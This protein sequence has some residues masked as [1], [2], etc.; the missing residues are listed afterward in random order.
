MYYKKEKFTSEAFSAEQQ[1]NNIQECDLAIIEGSCP[2]TIQIGLEM[3]MILE[4]GKPVIFLYKEGMSPLFINAISSIKLIKSE[5]T[6]SDLEDTLGWCL[7]EL[8][9]ISN[10]R[11]TFFISQEIE[12]F[13]RK[14]ASKNKLSKSEFIRHLIKKEMK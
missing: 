9:H 11:F 14:T 4:R 7:E 5:Y 12:E 10:R 8:D 2:S 3:T 1:I 6:E 13:I